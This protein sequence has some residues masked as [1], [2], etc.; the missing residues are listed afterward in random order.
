MY[1]GGHLGKPRVLILAPTGVGTVNID[2]TT[3]HIASRIT[4]DSKL[5]PLNDH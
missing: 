2:G 3:N 1:K 4:V 5:Y